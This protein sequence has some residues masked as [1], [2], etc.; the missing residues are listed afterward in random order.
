[1][2]LQSDLKTTK[3]HLA[4][5]EAR[6]NAAETLLKDQDQLLKLFDFPAQHWI[7][8]RTSNA[9]E[10][11]F[12]TVKAR[13]RT[14]RCAGS[15]KAGL[16]LAF[17]LLE[18]VEGRWRRINAPHLVALVRAGE[19]FPDGEHEM[20]QDNIWAGDEYRQDREPVESASLACAAHAL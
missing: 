12:S 1:M 4:D 15:R 3:E 5:A 9:I 16:A 7:H 11:A 8:L 17:K 2:E 20:F 18:A 6:A 10:S 19:K 14:T 13:T